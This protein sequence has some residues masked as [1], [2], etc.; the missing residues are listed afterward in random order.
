VEISANI[1]H[2]KMKTANWLLG[3]FIILLTTLVNGKVSG[4]ARPNFVGCQD[5][6]YVTK[7]CTCNAQ[8]FQPVCACN[9]VTY[10]NSCLAQNC[11]A[12]ANSNW[13]DGPCEPATFM[14]NPNP[15]SSGQDLILDLESKEDATV[16]IYIFDLYGK[17]YFAQRY[18]LY[19]LT[20]T[21]SNTISIGGYPNGVY[22]MLLRMP[23]GYFSVKRFV[24]QNI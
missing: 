13:V 1:C 23:S 6:L 19:K 3:A 2:L 16:Y 20:P 17:Q 5:S 9:K 11:G 21:P 7:Y 8:D 4:Q 24:V 10:R 15:V 18:Y 14:F 22:L 12:I